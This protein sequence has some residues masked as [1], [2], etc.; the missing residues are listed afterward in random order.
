MPLPS[1]T[2]NKRMKERNHHQGR[3]LLEQ[4]PRFLSSQKHAPSLR[5]TINAKGAK[6]KEMSVV[7]V[8]KMDME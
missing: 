1:V 5:V 7:G 8:Q 3:R 4:K 2:P 6:K